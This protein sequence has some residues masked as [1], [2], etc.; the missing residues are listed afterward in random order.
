MK[1]NILLVDDDTIFNFINKRMIENTGMSNE[2]D[3]ALNGKQALD[4]LNGYLSG[5]RSIPDVIFLDLD[6]PIMDGFSFLEAFKRLNMPHKEK[7]SIVIVTS[8]Q[9]PE[10]IKRAKSFGIDH[11]LTKPI[12]EEQ[13]LIALEGNLVESGHNN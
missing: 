5:A 1:K 6:M 9:N 11:Y 13:V 7:V 4:L 3:T 2:V 8:S 12:T 10:D